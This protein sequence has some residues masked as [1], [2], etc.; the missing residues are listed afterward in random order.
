[1]TCVVS[2]WYVGVGAILGISEREEEEEEEEEEEWARSCIGNIEDRT[3]H[4]LCDVRVEYDWVQSSLDL[5]SAGKAVPE[6]FACSSSILV[7]SSAVHVLSHYV[8]CYA[9]ATSEGVA[10]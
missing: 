6:V 9:Y 8:V 4:E 10:P 5:H 1:M 3:G 7:W 2:P